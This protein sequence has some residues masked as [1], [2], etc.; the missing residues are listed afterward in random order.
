MMTLSLVLSPLTE[1]GE[2]VI[3]ALTVRSWRLSFVS[4]LLKSRVMD[5]HRWTRIQ[6][7]SARISSGTLETARERRGLRK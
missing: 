5:K 1:W 6:T 7:I 4:R 2:K 3:A